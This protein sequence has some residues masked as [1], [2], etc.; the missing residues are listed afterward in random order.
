MNNI[1]T[2]LWRSL[3]FWFALKQ[4]NISQAKGILKEIENSGV[5]L[6]SLQKLY[7]DKLKFQESLNE[8]DREISNLNKA[9]KKAVYKLDELELKIDFDDLIIRRLDDYILTPEPKFIEFV[10]K[11]FKLI[12]KSENLWQCTGIYGELF[13]NF[14]SNLAEYIKV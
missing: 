3:R 10:S 1:F 8:K 7:Q 14:E 11:S 12:E 9:L 6:S 4:G 5:K 13:D 2:N